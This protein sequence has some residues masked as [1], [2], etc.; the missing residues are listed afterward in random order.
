HHGRGAGQGR[1][2]VAGAAGVP[3]LPRAAV[4]LLHARVP[5]HDYRRA[6]RES[7][8]DRGRGARD[9]GRQPVPVH[10]LPEHRRRRAAGRGAV[11]MGGGASRRGGPASRSSAWRITAWSAAGAPTW[12]TWARTPTRLRS[13]DRRTPTPASSTSTSPTRST[14]TG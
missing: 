2:V 14:S 8:A 6:A 9:G 4:R 3:R 13:C 10:R 1:A 7:A 11:T 12:T 5:D